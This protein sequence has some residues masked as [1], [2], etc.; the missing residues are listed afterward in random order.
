MSGAV[1]LPDD[2][3]ASPEG[4]G[5][6]VGVVGAVPVIADGALEKKRARGFVLVPRVDPADVD[7]LAPGVGALGAP[8]SLRAEVHGT[9][10]EL[11]ATIDAEL[12][13]GSVHGD[14]TARV[15]D[16]HD[17]SMSAHARVRLVDV[18]AHDAVATAPETRIGAVLEVDASLLGDVVEGDFRLD[19]EPSEAAGQSVPAVALHGRFDRQN[20]VVAGHVAEPGAPSEI[21]AHVRTRAGADSP[22]DVDAVVTSDV[23]LAKLTRVQGLGSGAVHA[24]AT[25]HLDL[26]PERDAR[27]RR[28]GGE[29]LRARGRRRRA[30]ARARVG[31]GAL[32]DPRFAARVDGEALAASGYAL[33]TFH[34][35]AS[36]TQHQFNVAASGKG[37]GRTPSIDAR[38]VVAL[39]AGVRVRG[40][41]ATISRDD[42]TAHA[43]VD[44]VTIGGG[45]LAVRGA[46]VT[47]LGAP[48]EAS[49]RTSAGA[50][51]LTA[52][53]TDVDFACVKALLAL[54]GVDAAGHASLDV[55]LRADARGAHGRVDVGVTGVRYGAIDGATA[56][57]RGAIDGLDVTG[58]ASA[59]LGDAGHVDMTLTR[60]KLGGR[61]ATKQAWL[62]ATGE[63]VLDA[64]ADL[65]RVASLLPKDKLPLGV[66]VGVVS[67]K[68]SVSRAR[69]EDL[70]TLDLHG[71][72]KGVELAGVQTYETGDD[73]ARSLGPAPW[74]VEGIDAG[75]EAK[76]DARAG[77]AHAALTLDDGKGRLA[78]L[79]ADVHAP[80]DA[81]VRGATSMNDAVSRATFAAHAHVPRRELEAL[82][83]VIRAAVPAR[84]VV[85]L[86]VDASGDMAHPAVRLSAKGE[87]LLAHDVSRLVKPTDVTLD[88]SYEN[89]RGEL[90]A[91]AATDGHDVL[92]ARAS[93]ETEAADV[94]RGRVSAAWVASADVKMTALPIE[95]LAGFAG[96][97]ARGRLDGEIKLTDLHRDAALAVDL[98]LSDVVV[99]RAHVD[100]VRAVVSVKG[101]A[102]DAHAQVVQP[103]GYADLTAKGGVAWGAA[104]TP[105][106]DARAPVDAALLAKNL[107]IDAV[108]PFV[109]E[110]VSEID[111]RLDA[112]VKAHLDHVNAAGKVTGAVAL[113]E[114]VV[115]IPALGERLHSVQ[116]KVTMDPWGVVKIEQIYAQAG[117]G[118]FTAA[119]RATMSGLVLQHAEGAVR[120]PKGEAMPIAIEGVPM[121]SAYG[122][123]KILAALSPD[124]KR[125]GVTVDVPTLGV[126]LP[127]STGHAVQDLEADEH[128]RI[129]A[130]HTSGFDLVATG[131]PKKPKGPSGSLIHASVR[132]GEVQVRRDTSLR[133]TV[134]GTPVF[135]VGRATKASG[136]ILVKSGTIDVQGKRFTLDH[137]IVTFTGDPSEP[138]IVATAY[139]D[140]PD[141]TRVY[142]DFA[143]TPKTGKLVMRSEPAHTQDEIVALVLFGAADGQL[144]GTTP[145]S[146]GES[147]AVKGVGLTGGV[148]AQGLNRAISGATSVDVEARVDTSDA[149]NPKPELVV[150]LTPRL[151]ADVA[152]ALGTPPPG[153]NPDKTTLTLDFRFHQNWSVD[154][155][156]GDAGSSAVDLVWRRRY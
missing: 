7:A 80:L 121:G 66:A 84:G 68:G 58:E 3:K 20:A 145:A 35:A 32:A 25:A 79:G 40:V 62:Y 6:F 93:L 4:S 2:A 33:P 78:E 125:I 60:V 135:D 146:S 154:A 130:H 26:V 151:S 111:G 87:K 108:G 17:A 23:D 137:G 63:I 124:Q 117:A 115:E 37:A 102:L 126:N 69:V 36:G 141:G 97:R 119:G 88:A 21:E 133:A 99:R 44:D 107:R 128:V 138:Q 59:S 41:D 132:L 136:K 86:D 110:D 55:D 28:R 76:I 91:T 98:T 74:H 127:Q 13:V 72:T 150:Q 31:R 96:E 90:H 9:L 45:A 50:V 83:P 120:I 54:D 144:G 89:G 29:P 140:A 49:L 92:E 134:T 22:T 155:M 27:E 14:A 82:P 51:A 53:S 81:L 143:G 18:D 95:A 15:P 109:R 148:M 67:M 113:R 139:W 106:I 153:Q 101:G 71:A 152:Y 147:T 123:I 10:P 12:G 142:A 118:S 77:V 131:A 75:W 61:P 30:R 16:D 65:A 47:G 1:W 114:G 24:K 73:G 105:T 34:V 39:G 5:R 116:G 43:T 94:E 8:V 46:R 42:V 52:K 129:G 156:V 103:G 56:R 149:D 64:T 112:D 100:K 38:A 57:V 11:A 19:G 122:D 104:L 48:I 70:P 85:S